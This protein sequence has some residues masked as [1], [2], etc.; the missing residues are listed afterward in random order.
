M[1]LPGELRADRLLL[2]RWRLEDREPFAAMNADLRVMEFFSKPLSREESDARADRIEAEFAEHGH[3]LWA[4]EIPGLTPFAGFIG[5]TS[6]Q[7]EAKFTPCIEIGWRLAFEYWGRGYAPEGA[8]AV[9][10]F[11]FEQLGLDQIVS[12]TAVQ[13]LRSRRVMEKIG[14]KHDPRENFD[15]PLLPPGHW[16]SRHVLYRIARA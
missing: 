14:M 12:T 9:I 16:L 3:G 6:P 13:N 8:L 4:V 5:L 15:H 1:E 2:R 11:G 7:F 10:K